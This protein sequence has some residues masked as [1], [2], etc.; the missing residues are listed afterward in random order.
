MLSKIVL[1]YIICRFGIPKRILS[2]N[3]TPFVGQLFELLLSEYQ[4]YH[5]KSTRYY[6]KGNGAV[7][8][9]NKSLAS[10][11]GKMIQ[12]ASLTWDDCLP[13]ALWAYRTTKST[14]TKQTPFALVYGAEGVLPIEIKVPSAR[15]SLSTNHDENSRLFDPEALEGKRAEAQ[16]SLQVYQRKVL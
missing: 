8:A 7:E 6:P 10:I 9:F 3:G 1:E 14:T 15:M 12:E 16:K 11:L 2:D 5:G 13:L 4:I